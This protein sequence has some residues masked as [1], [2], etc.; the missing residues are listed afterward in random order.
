MKKHLIKFG[1][2]S[3][4]AVSSLSLLLSCSSFGEVVPVGKIS[5]FDGYYRPS[6]YSLN[7]QDINNSVLRY[8]L[9][10]VGD[11][12][13][14][15]VPVY[16]SDGPT[17]TPLMQ[18]N[19]NTAFFGN[20][21]DTAW[22]SVSSFYKKSSYGQ[23]NIS[24]EVYSTP[25]RISLTTVE[26]N[27]MVDAELS[28]KVASDFQKTSI[29]S[30]KLK[31]YDKDNDGF[32]DAVCFIYSSNFRGGTNLWAW[33]TWTNE[34]ANRNRPTFNNHMWA[35]YHFT[36]YVYNTGIDSLTFIHETGHLLGLDDYYGGAGSYSPL[37]GPDMM[38]LNIVDHNAFTKTV[39]NWVY[40][41]IVD[42]TKEKTV[43]EISSF[44]ET[45]EA[46]I[47][48]NKW[49]GSAF[50]EYLL[51]EFYTPTG[52]NYKQSILPT[53]LRLKTKGFSIPGVKIYHVDARLAELNNNKGRLEFKNYVTTKPNFEKN[54]YLPAASN[55]A[56]ATFVQSDFKLIHLME[57]SGTNSFKQGSYANN[58]TLFQAGDS[59][60]PSAVFFP[61][62]TRFNSGL[63]ANYTINILD[64]GSTKATI[65]IQKN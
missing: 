22:E 46:I 29:S 19:L 15:V 28:A 32:V 16:F 52:L 41:Y 59:F 43:I 44:V 57:A 37:G 8:T 36:N 17:W 24:G 5:Q 38:D 18:E 20:S 42:G 34:R 51:V 7:N 23:L 48:N 55:L 40:P 60:T 14:L 10:P 6:E 12:K 39:S 3:L 9:N 61:K 2:V 63:S 13:L 47:I 56:K 50:D 25:Y 30:D 33:V 11:Q 4:V 64:I 53:D 45:G 21:A 62:G 26:A 35:S 31:E 58:M 65:E 54:Y 49:N 1:F 27:R